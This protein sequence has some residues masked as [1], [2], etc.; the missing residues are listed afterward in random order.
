MQKAPVLLFTFNRPE[1]TEKTLTALSQNEG[2]KYTDLFIFSDGP[3]NKTDYTAVHK[4]RKLINLNEWNY[5]FNTIQIVENLENKGLAASIINGVTSIFNSYESVIVLEDDLL[6]TQDFLT[7][8]NTCL[9]NYKGM[10]K[11]GSVTGYN[12][13]VSMPADY[14]YDVYF[15]TRSSSYGW[16]T[17]R[18]IWQNVDWDA[19]AYSSFKKSYNQRKNFN[20]TGYDRAKR[21]DLQMTKGANSW[22]V[23]FGFHLFVNNLFTI[24]SSNSKILN[25]GWDGSG[26]HKNRDTNKL[27]NK[28]L[29]SE[30]PLRLPR[31]ITAETDIIKRIQIVYGND[32]FVKLKDFIIHVKNRWI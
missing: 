28:I 16:G 19:N 12:P 17:W 21:L 8:M 23:I 2:A 3:R 27:N 4:V 25:I 31:H 14:S 20:L 13:I 18:D 1:H 32:F 29:L 22:S 5:K 11:T 7:F 15:S 26:T 9:N 30:Y 6:T 10:E 24:H